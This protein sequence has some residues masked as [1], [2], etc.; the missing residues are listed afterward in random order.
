MRYYIYRI[1]FEDG[2]SYVGSHVEKFENDGYVTSSS[3]YLN[4][5]SKIIRRDIICECKDFYTMS[6][7]ESI[8]IMDDKSLNNKNVNGNYGNWYYN[9]CG[10]HG[11]HSQNTKNKISNSLK[12]MDSKK[13]KECKEKVSKSLKNRKVSEE[14][15]K[16]HSD[17]W[18]NLPEKE[19]K[20]IF[21]KLV[22]IK[23][24]NNKLNLSKE[25][26]NK[27]SNSLKEYYRNNLSVWKGRTHSNETK[28]KI[29][30]SLKGKPSW[31]SGK[32]M[33]DE[34]KAEHRANL[35]K[36]KGCK[37]TEEHK[38]LIRKNSRNAVRIKNVES[39]IEY[40]SIRQAFL[41]DE[42]LKT[43]PRPRTRTALLELFEKL[44][45]E[46]VKFILL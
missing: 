26:K 8:A 9:F 36:R 23:K 4:N 17:Y 11:H 12:N 10:F 37:L 19:K 30:N 20:L 24:A 13:K 3:Y 29:S 46:E 32:T 31:N 45:K 41:Q 44:N 5:N 6:L 39:G 7:I 21:E 22:N 33:T 25:T 16:K 42:I 14:T 38:N 18:K 40:Y 34:W 1:E 28:I 15:K 2:S 27:I 43:F 35:G